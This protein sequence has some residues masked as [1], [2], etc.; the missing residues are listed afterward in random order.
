MEGYE[1]SRKLEKL[2]WRASDT[3]ELAFGDVFVP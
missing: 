3:A 2:G 1:V